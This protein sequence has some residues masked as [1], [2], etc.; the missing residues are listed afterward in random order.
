MKVEFESAPWGKYTPN[1]L[2]L[3]AQKILAQPLWA[4][5]ADAWKRTRDGAQ[6]AGKIPPQGIQST[7]NELVDD[8][9]EKNGWEVEGGRCW[10]DGTWVRVTFR[11]VM[12]LGSDLVDAMVAHSKRG[13]TQTC[14]IAANGSFLRQISPNEVNSLC[15]YEKFRELL[16]DLKGAVNFPLVLGK[17]IPSNPLPAD[18]Q[19][20]VDKPRPRRKA[21][22]PR[23]EAPL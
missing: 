21:S 19:A 4:Q 22:V 10:K 20:A 16:F 14:L 15:S 7:L 13:A 17:L 11:H 12:S 8:A 3:E 18:L 2:V 6:K 9:M 23:A 5:A 1:A